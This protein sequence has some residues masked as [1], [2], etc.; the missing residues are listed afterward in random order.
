MFRPA[1]TLVV[2]SEDTTLA[3]NSAN[4]SS[5]LTGGEKTPASGTAEPESSAQWTEILQNHS[6]VLSLIHHD[7]KSPL[8][9]LE[10]IAGLLLDNFNTMSTEEQL[11]LI[12]LI[13]R[14][15]AQTF[16]L[17]DQ[18]FTWAHTQTSLLQSVPKPILL[19]TFLKET[20]L[21]SANNAEKKTI[22]LILEC[23]EDI[24]ISADENMLG[25]VV[26]NLVANAVKFTA[27]DG[28]IQVNCKVKGD[29]VEVR[30]QDSGVGMNPETL[31]KIFVDPIHKSNLGTA[32]EKGTGLGL[33][34][35]KSFSDK[36]SWPI[37]VTSQPG[38]GTEFLLSLPLLVD[39]SLK[40]ASA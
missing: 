37:S 20:L 30:I 15:S 28:K 1:D 12:S 23:A 10:G 6:R 18:L 35:V 31:A 24:W 2:I 3:Q 34:L 27:S 39:F 19:A 4:P 22:Q 36:N 9:G 33:S 26:Q 7:L 21:L 32:G 16:R 25:S 13:H 11:R 29:C 17:V 8:L 40:R 14:T 38:S 5:A